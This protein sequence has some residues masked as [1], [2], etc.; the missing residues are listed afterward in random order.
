MDEVGGTSSSH[1]QEVIKIFLKSC[2][3][4]L[5]SYKKEENVKTRETIKKDAPRE[6]GQNIIPC[7]IKNGNGGL[8]NDLYIMP[9]RHASNDNS[10]ILFKILLELTTCK[11]LKF[12]REK[13]IFF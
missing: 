8:I 7:V 9:S 1:H 10:L 3:K 12:L 5:K 6:R 2:C 4:P 11:S 13:N